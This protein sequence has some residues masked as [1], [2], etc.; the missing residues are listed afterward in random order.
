[1]DRREALKHILEAYR[2]NPIPG[3]LEAALDG[4]EELF[5]PKDECKSL[6]ERK[7]EFL[8]SIR[9]HLDKY[10]KDMCNQFGLYWLEKTPKGRKYRFEKEKVFDVPRRLATWAKNNK[11]FSIVN[12]LRK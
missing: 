6:E 5:E 7:R 2:C 1:M 9:P 12:M 10:G 8:D 11:K 3:Q 4:I